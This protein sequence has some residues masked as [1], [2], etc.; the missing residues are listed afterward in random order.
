MVLSDGDILEYINQK[1][2]IVTPIRADQI[3]PASIDICLGNTFCTLEDNES[4]TVSL[5]EKLEYKKITQESFNLLPGQFV[6]ASSR[7]YVSLPTDLAAFVE[8]R[9]SLGRMGLFI[10]NAAWIEPGFSGEITLELFN[11]SKSTI[12]LH[13][14]YR[15]GQLIFVKTLASVQHPYTGK[16]Q[17]QRGATGSREY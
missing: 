3:Q 15:I 12:E 2:L 1:K 17:H 4:R 7:E 8:G 9:S 10:Q 11:A 16:Y 14:G 13:S 5:G 6:L